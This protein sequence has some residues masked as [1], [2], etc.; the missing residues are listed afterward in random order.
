MVPND[1]ILIREIR[2]WLKINSLID[3]SELDIHGIPESLFNLLPV[4]ERFKLLNRQIKGL[5]LQQQRLLHYLSRD[6][7][8]ALIIETMEYSSPELFWLDKAI[9][10]K[11]VDPT[12]RQQDVLRVFAENASLLEAIIEI[13]EVMDAE[14]EKLKNKKYRNW[15]FL[16]APVIL[17]FLF[18]FIY[19]L[20]VKPDYQSLYDQYKS[21]YVPVMSAIDTVSYEG[22]SYHEALL[23]MEEGNLSLSAKLF[24][25]LIPVD[26]SY[27]ASSR[28]FLALINLHEGDVPS[29][30]EQL[31]ALRTE[32]EKFYREVAEKLYRKISR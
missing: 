2:K 8:P 4:E 16:S 19:P 1:N 5:Q 9:L 20:L 26:S 22:G 18:L 32:D 31:N 25:E 14:A 27:R 30:R 28:W 12:A 17:L 7:D 13:S 24:E 11:E 3:G 23:L 15:L 10:V 29:C 6:I 21:V